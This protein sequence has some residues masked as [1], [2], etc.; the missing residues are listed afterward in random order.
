M[1][2]LLNH[3][4]SSDEDVSSA[5]MTGSFFGLPCKLQHHPHSLQCLSLPKSRIGN[6]YVYLNNKAPSMDTCGA[7]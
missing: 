3:P 4:K 7:P 2:L 5:L 1:K 6:I